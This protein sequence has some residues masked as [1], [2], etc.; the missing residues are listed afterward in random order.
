MDA[1]G[2]ALYDEYSIGD[3]FLERN[4]VPKNIEGY[5]GVVGAFSVGGITTYKISSPTYIP[6]ENALLEFDAYCR[7]DF[8]LKIA[9]DTGDMEHDY[10]RFVYETQ[11]KGGGKW[12]RIILKAGDFKGENSGMP[13]HSF[14]EGRALTFDCDD[15]RVEYAVTNILWL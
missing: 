13:L 10:E 3:I 14:R 7:E 6:D 1:F 2:V 9:V 4:A 15:E 12:K 8:I 11:I 5:G